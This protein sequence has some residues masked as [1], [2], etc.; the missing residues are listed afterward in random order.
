MTINEAFYS[1][2]QDLQAIYDAQEAAAIAHEVLFTLTGLEKMERLAKKDTPLTSEQRTKFEDV[3]A[4]LKKGEPMQYALGEAWFMG[5]SFYVN[6]AV[7]IPRPETEELVD[8]IIKD[9][10]NK[11]DN[12]SVLDIGTG[13]GCIP[14]SLQ[15]A[16]RD[17][18]V[19]SMDV[20]ADALSVAKRNAT[21]LGAGVH[22]YENNFLNTD[23]WNG[24]PKYDIIVSNP[25]YIPES[26]KETMHSNVKDHE[27][28]LA[29]FVPND[30][31][32]LF[33]RNI[34]DF[35]RTHLTENGIVY[36]EL[37]LEY[38]QATQQLFEEKGYK[39]VEIRKD[40]HGNWRM[41]RAE[42]LSLCS[43]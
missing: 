3:A 4:A 6:N 32:L 2:K 8:W 38:A 28:S 20:S 35:G 5:R 25:P 33:Y 40:M 15:L 37:H 12:I 30:D 9:Q 42:Y 43:S 29:L 19:S 39:N 34:A 11:T 17:A 21:T 24:F 14:I 18:D 41:L 13:S 31:A 1:L 16:L 27:P 23:T 7:L 10:K 22:F 26:D 36:C